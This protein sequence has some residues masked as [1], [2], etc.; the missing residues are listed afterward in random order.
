LLKALG[1]EK[2]QSY[3]LYMLRQDQLSASSFPLGELRDKSVTRS[4]ARELNLPIAEKPDSQEICFVSEAGGY[5]EFLRKVKPDA[6]S[7]G[8]IVDESGK[9]LTA[10]KGIA[11]FTVGQRKGIGLTI[12]SGK[13]LFV[14]K[15]EPSTNHVVVGLED[16]LLTSEVLLEDM[17]W[18]KTQPDETPIEVMAK[19]RYN[20]EAKPARLFGGATPRLEFKKPV[21]AVTPGQIAV[22]YVGKTVAAGGTIR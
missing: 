16:A 7:E 1:T 6:F 10:H 8:E 9:V 20:M 22:A 3:V 14:L 19:I 11:D 12:P 21:R 4:L 18:G 2:D 17:F 13:P 15:I 5:R